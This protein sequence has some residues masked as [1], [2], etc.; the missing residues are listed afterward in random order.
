M[1]P[2]H[3]YGSVYFLVSHPSSPHFTLLNAHLL[4]PTL[5]PTPNIR[6]GTARTS[7]ADQL[8]EIE[9]T[10]NSSPPH[11]KIT[12]LFKLRGFTLGRALLSTFSR[13]SEASRPFTKQ[14]CRIEKN[15]LTGKRLRGQT[16]E[17]NVAE[18][19]YWNVRVLAHVSSQRDVW[20]LVRMGEPFCRLGNLEM[21]LGV[22]GLGWGFSMVEERRDARKGGA[23]LEEG[24]LVPARGCD[25]TMN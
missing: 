17:R 9:I 22:D 23:G 14:V 4:P 15:G 12:L 7:F 18:G 19:Q 20:S 1:T 25:V 24:V 3:T 11:D 10:E 21:R 5:N 8:L 2:T 16:I 13:P 6:H